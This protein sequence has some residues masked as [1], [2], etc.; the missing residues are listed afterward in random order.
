[1]KSPLKA[2]GCQFYLVTSLKYFSFTSAVRTVLILPYIMTVLI[3]F[4]SAITCTT[5]LVMSVP[6][7]ARPQ[8]CFV[9]LSL[10]LQLNFF[11]VV[12]LG[13]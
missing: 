8:F 13:K 3:L 4:Y 5:L 10:T 9:R 1:M 2:F 7:D 6:G 11:Y 12:A